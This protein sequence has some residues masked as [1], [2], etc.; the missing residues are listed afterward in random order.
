[1]TNRLVTSTSFSTFIASLDSFYNTRDC[2][3]IEVAKAREAETT[4]SIAALDDSDVSFRPISPES[5]RPIKTSA[6]VSSSG[7]LKTQDVDQAHKKPVGHLERD[8]VRR[9][10]ATK[11]D[12]HRPATAASASHS[13]SGW[14]SSATAATLQDSHTS[15]AS[16]PLSHSRWAGRQPPSLNTTKQC[17]ITSM[18]YTVSSQN[19]SPVR[20]TTLNPPSFPGFYDNLQPC[21]T[22]KSKSITPHHLDVEDKH[23]NN[24]WKRIDAPGNRLQFYSESQE[25]DALLSS[26]SANSG[27]LKTSGWATCNASAQAEWVS[28]DGTRKENCGTNIPE[29][30]ELKSKVQVNPA[31]IGTFKRHEQRQFIRY[32]Q[33]FL[34]SFSDYRVAP[35]HI[36][37]VVASIL[38]SPNAFKARIAASSKALP[39]HNQHNNYNYHNNNNCSSN[40]TKKA[41]KDIPQT[42]PSLQLS[43]VKK[44]PSA[45]GG[46]PCDAKMQNPVTAQEQRVAQAKK[47]PLVSAQ[48]G[49][50]SVSG[51]LG[52]KVFELK[53]PR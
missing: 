36:E 49:R 41:G 3:K 11:F 39:D 46:R 44:N 21:K 33:E 10:A 26:G 52:G 32:S 34:L 43:G 51:G 14:R 5:H 22:Y 12:T 20:P 4:D 15:V 50:A 17:N 42:V 40:M 37:Q 7:R 48:E 25:D 18:D 8:R 2:H 28:A 6:K 45:E 27:S 30:Q 23:V 16:V 29:R 38:E 9:P 31:A 24:K 47:K 1:M 19:T 35:S 53:K 13:H